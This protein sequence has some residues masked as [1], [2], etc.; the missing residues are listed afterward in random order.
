ISARIGLPAR[1]KPVTSSG[2][3][4]TQHAGQGEA[5]VGMVSSHDI[6]AQMEKGFPVALSFPQEGTGWEIGGMALLNRAKHANIAKAW[7]DWALE[8][9]TRKRGY[10]ARIGLALEADEEE[11]AWPSPWV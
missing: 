7:F 4:L 8:S 3:A 5:A 1:L 10:G 11:S 9:A 2:A 6:V